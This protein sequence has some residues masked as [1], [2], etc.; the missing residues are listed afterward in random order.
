VGLIR[1]Q[2]AQIPVSGQI[3]LLIIKPTEIIIIDYKTTAHVAKELSEVSLNY[4]L[5][6]KIYHAL[7]SQL[8][9]GLPVRCAIVW[10]HVPSLMWLDE[11]VAATPFPD[12][13][14]MV[15][16]AVAA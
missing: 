15:K 4:L 2:N 10:T 5:Q 1:H 8:Y 9:P 14:T 3:D 11:A 6:L 16:S 13:N 12:K 7:V